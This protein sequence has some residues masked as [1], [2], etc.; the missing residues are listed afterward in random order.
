MTDIK[1]YFRYDNF[2]TKS[3]LPQAALQFSAETQATSSV[4]RILEIIPGNIIRKNGAI[5]I[6]PAKAAPSL[7]F[8]K[9]FAASVRCTMT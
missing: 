5:F 7:A 3:E 2:Y 6:R 9:S 8:D 4:K 1:F